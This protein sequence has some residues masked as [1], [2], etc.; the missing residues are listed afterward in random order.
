[1]LI[2]VSVV[3]LAGEEVVNYGFLQL[4]APLVIA[5]GQYALQL[6][7]RRFSSR[8]SFLFSFPPSTSTDSTSTTL[9]FAKSNKR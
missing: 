5:F 8:D 9:F 2:I 4:G 7:S 3:P 6:R 1:V